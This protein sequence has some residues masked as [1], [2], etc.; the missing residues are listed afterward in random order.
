MIQPSTH[1]M[2]SSMGIRLK[3]VHCWVSTSNAVRTMLL[4]RP[5]AL[6]EPVKEA[7]LNQLQSCS[8]KRRDELAV[9]GGGMQ[10]DGRM[11]LFCCQHQFHHKHA[12]FPVH[13]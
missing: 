4:L 13:Q 6:L 7:A 12:A 9:M 2:K 8:P 3:Y 11:A 10:L 1:G 5:A